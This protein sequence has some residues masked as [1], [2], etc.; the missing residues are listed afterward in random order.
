[1]HTIREVP[2]DVRISKGPLTWQVKE[3]MVSTLE[4][5]KSQMVQDQESGG[6]SVL[7]WLATPVAMFHG[8][9]QKFGNK[10]KI[11]NKVQFGNTFTNWCN[12]WSIEGVNVYGHVPE[13]HATFGR[14]RFHNVWWDPH[15]DHKTWNSTKLVWVVKITLFS[16]T[17]TLGQEIF[18][19]IKE[20][21]F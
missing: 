10:V 1:M 15:N 20:G 21:I 4:Q 12:V 16:G 14:G 7:C 9:L 3:R 17:A 2:R 13:C 8:N 18:Q 19:K 11:G 5:C 6:A